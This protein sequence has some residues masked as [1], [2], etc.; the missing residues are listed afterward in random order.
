MVIRSLLR[1]CFMSIEW[2]LSCAGNADVAA[3]TTMSGGYRELPASASRG[4]D[5]ALGG[6]TDYIDEALHEMTRQQACTALRSIALIGL[7]TTV[8][9]RYAAGATYYISA[10]S[11][12]PANVGGAGTA[13]NP[14]VNL[15]N[16]L[17][18]HTFSP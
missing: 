14:W 10:A 7:L 4:L 16:A 17:T 9:A 1:N 12:D 15:C 2:L 6:I 5:F 11:P 8:E 13:A 18:T 3:I